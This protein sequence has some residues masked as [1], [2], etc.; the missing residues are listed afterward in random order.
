MAE[1]KSASDDD[2]QT[3]EEEEKQ[4]TQEQRDALLMTAVKDNNIE[5]VQEALRIGANVDAE[6]NSWNPI[7]W[8]ACNGNE[9]IVRLLIKNGAHNKYK[10]QEVADNE[11]DGD[12]EE[13]IDNFKPVPD[14]AKTGR[15]TPMHWA[16][17]HGHIKVV[18]LLMKEKMNPLLQ[19]IHGNNCIHQAAANSQIDVLKCFM[20]FGV[21]L[22]LKN[23]R[24]H[25]PLDL[26]TDPETRALIT[27]GIK[28]THCSGKKCGK[29]KF[30]FRNI[31]FFCSNC[32]KFFCKMCSTKSWVFENEQSETEERP[33]CRC[34]DCSSLIR[35]GQQSLVD[36]MNTNNFDTC[37]RV[38]KM[39]KEAGTD[40]DVKL[41]DKAAVQHLK[42]EKE[43]DIRN[44]IKSVE[45]VSDY[46]TIRKSVTVLNK[47]HQDAEKLGVKIDQQL[48]Q[49]INECAQ[50]LI[51]ERNLRFEME[52]M[53]VS[54]ATKDTVEKL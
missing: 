54:A 39:L 43:L 29:S 38:F 18:W 17:Y 52:T 36:A 51:S 30:D 50:R 28:T 12:E 24:V 44:F 48:I 26:A 8:A 41:L 19:D 16:S 46:K 53:H 33:V 49:E 13:E 6:E 4:M 5:E 3:E 2:D 21:D 35:E 40:I 15:H 32:Q 22:N 7:L 34:D 20:Q 47:K 9:D 1:P 31:Q 42:L 37:D 23:A 14:P 27:S 45:H 25:T 11:G 10:E